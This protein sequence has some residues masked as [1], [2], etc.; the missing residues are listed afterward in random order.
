MKDNRTSIDKLELHRQFLG[1]KQSEL[2]Q[3]INVQASTYYRWRQEGTT[4]KNEKR[5]HD[6]LR[7]F[8]KKQTL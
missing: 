2:C 7:K 6:A 3:A 1:M 5:V 8:A 4:A